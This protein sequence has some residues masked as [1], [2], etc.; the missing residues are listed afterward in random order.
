MTLLEFL[1][2]WFVSLEQF[3]TDREITG[4]LSRSPED[5]RPKAFRGV[6]LRR[7]A[8]EGELLLWDT[9]EAE[10]N[11][12]PLGE[13]PTQEHLELEGTRELAEALARLLAV[14]TPTEPESGPR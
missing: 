13:G 1:E 10:L 7:G 4:H 3:L 6:S 11:L 9:G 8:V 12:M 5:G 14:V 2:S